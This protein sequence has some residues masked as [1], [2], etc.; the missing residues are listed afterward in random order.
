VV[1]ISKQYGRQSRS[2]NSPTKK[3]KLKRTP[4]AVPDNT[5]PPSQPSNVHNR[6]RERDVE[7]YLVQALDGIGIPCL[8]FHPDS[9]V[10]MPD[11]VCLLPDNKVLWIELKTDG[12]KLAMVQRLRHKELAEHGQSVRVVW[13]KSDADTLVAEL[14][15]MKNSP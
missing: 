15:S 9:K 14:D 3:P 13:N 2:D 11:R 12:G 1:N 8:K 6:T 10:G 5:T 7:Q 4:S